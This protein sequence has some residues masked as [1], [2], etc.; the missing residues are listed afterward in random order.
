MYVSAGWLALV[1]GY[2]GWELLSAF[3]WPGLA[4]LA[5][6]LASGVAA[7]RGDLECRSL[8]ARLRQKDEQFRAPGVGPNA[9]ELA[10]KIDEGVAG[11]GGGWFRNQ[12]EAGRHGPVPA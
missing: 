12:E 7:A 8:A 11:E 2:L 6:A 3:A 9:D 5:V 10:A 1:A 4:G